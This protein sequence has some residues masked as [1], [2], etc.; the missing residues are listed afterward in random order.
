MGAHWLLATGYRLSAITHLRR[1]SLATN[2][3]SITYMQRASE[4]KD[5]GAC[6]HTLNKNLR[7]R[8]VVFLN[9]ER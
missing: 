6:F 8:G 9:A 2:L 4:S 1:G 3:F 5:K 7:D